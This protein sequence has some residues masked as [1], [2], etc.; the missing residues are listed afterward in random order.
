LSRLGIFVRFNI[1][2]IP[3]MRGRNESV[4]LAGSDPA[5]FQV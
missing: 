4:K 2:A 1:L 3:Y 5:R